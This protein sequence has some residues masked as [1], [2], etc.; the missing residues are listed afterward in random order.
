VTPAVASAAVALGGLGLVVLALV[1]ARRPA[2]PVPERDGYLAEWQRLHGGFDPRTASVWVR[3]W[4]TVVHRVAAPMARRGVQPDVVTLASLWLALAVLVPAAAGGR[5]P[6]VAALLLVASGL[7]D[8]LDG[9]VAVLERRTSRWGYLLDSLVDR[10]SDVALLVAVVL[11]G[12]PVGLAVA[13]GVLLFMLEYTRARAGNA[14]GDDVGRVTLGE[15]PVRLILL[16]GTL[17]AAGALPQHAEL[18]TGVGTAVLAGVVAVGLG[19]L[20]VAVRRDLKA[21]SS[22]G[23]GGG[24]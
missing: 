6:L 23:P 9:C 14:G 1:T 17:L 5:W 12:A 16:A 11:V 19:Q 20:L 15:R 24:R 13:A 2:G 21:P 3:G 22:T 8:A 10:L 4:L 18:V 7:S